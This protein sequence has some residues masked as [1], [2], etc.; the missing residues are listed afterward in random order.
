M[1]IGIISRNTFLLSSTNPA[2]I[3]FSPF[4]NIFYLNTS[5]SCKRKQSFDLIDKFE[6]FN[7]KYSKDGEWN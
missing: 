2:I 5:A 1:F 4:I 3:K 6:N 7:A